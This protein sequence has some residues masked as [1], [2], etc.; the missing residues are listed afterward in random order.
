[1]KSLMKK[2]V[3]KSPIL[4]KVRKL[5]IEIL[6][7][8][9]QRNG[10]EI[11]HFFHIGKTGGTAIQNAFKNKKLTF[12][13]GYILV[14]ETH[15]YRFNDLPKDH[16][17][18]FIVRDPLTRFVSGFYS[19]Y[20]KGMPRIY[21]PWKNGEEEAFTEFPL[22]N[23]LGEALSSSDQNKKE[24]AKKAMSTI[25]HVKSSYYDW[26]HN[27]ETLKNNVNRISFVAVQ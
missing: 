22:P 4:R 11:V 18:F 23:T 8:W 10:K 21:N 6:I 27:T 16:K 13:K 9:H 7:K 17:T 1:M 20:R 14:F 26:F 2:L 24:R 3:R 12:G 19:R 5:H 25:G 15:S